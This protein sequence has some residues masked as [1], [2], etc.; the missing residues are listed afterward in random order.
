MYLGDKLEIYQT[1]WIF[2]SVLMVIFLHELFM[3]TTLLGLLE[4]RL[5]FEYGFV[6]NKQYHVWKLNK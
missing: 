5:K 4:C 2:M 3:V 1:C 6:E